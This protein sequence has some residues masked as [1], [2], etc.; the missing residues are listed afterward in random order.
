M[1]IDDVAWLLRFVGAAKRDL[2]VICGSVRFDNHAM[3]LQLL[4]RA[5]EQEQTITRI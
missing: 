5:H 4:V 3:L 2:A 1:D